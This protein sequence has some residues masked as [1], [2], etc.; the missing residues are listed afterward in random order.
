[1]PTKKTEFGPV[2]ELTKDKNGNSVA[3]VEGDIPNLDFLGEF[4]GEVMRE[5]DYVWAAK[6]LDIECAA[7][8]AFAIVESQGSRFLKMADKIVPR[9]LYERHRF[10]NFTKTLIAN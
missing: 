10:A 8:K 3:K 4:T 7:I 6:E 2:T 5:D 1:M 9:I